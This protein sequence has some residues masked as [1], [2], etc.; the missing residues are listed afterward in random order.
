MIFSEAIQ[1]ANHL[2]HLI[3]I[4]GKNHSRRDYED[5]I[6][7]VEYL[8]EYDPDNPLVEILCEK[9]DHYED[10]APE[11]AD[12]NRKLKQCDDAVA[13]LRT[14]MDQYNLNTTDF[15]NEIGSRSY[16]SRILNGE[17]NL[18]LEHMKKLAERFKL[19]VTIFI[20]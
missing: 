8:V 15:A 3:P 17:R 2:I 18:S 13:V 10:N 9:I 20:K 16:V 5:A 1:T 4:L 7:L 12:F 11:F 19:P 6:K 14:L